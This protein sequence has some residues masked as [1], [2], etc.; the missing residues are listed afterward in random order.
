MAT[1]KSAVKYL[2]DKYSITNVTQRGIKVT[3][4][5]AHLVKEL[6]DKFMEEYN[7]E[8]DLYHETDIRKV[9]TDDWYVKRFLLARNRDVH[10]SCQMMMEALKW[11][12]SEGIHD[13][14]GSYFPAEQFKLSSLFVY[15]PD[16]EGNITI[17]FRV[18]YVLKH[19]D[20]IPTLRKFGNYILQI[21]DEET[22]GSGITVIADFDET[23]IQNAAEV[24]LL[25]DAISTLKKY[26]P[27]G[28]NHIILLDLP[29]VLRAVW[30]M[31]KAWVPQN[32]RKLVEFVPRAD[33]HKIVDRNNLPD[34]LGGCCTIPYAGSKVVPS[35]SPPIYKFALENLGLPAKTAEKICEMYQ[36]PADRIE[37]ELNEREWYLKAKRIV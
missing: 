16:K 28:I 18:K 36:T 37:A 17:Y 13:L 8:K 5:S 25:F 4:R 32:R 14:D 2:V 20:M 1:T 35:G 23:G 12:K 30:G 15:A 9:L 6:R 21:V 27:F 7:K 19:V 34:F 26:F 29:W 11:K 22:N 33:I 24:D 31:A 3:N 10:E